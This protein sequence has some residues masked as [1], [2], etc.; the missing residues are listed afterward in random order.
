MFSAFFVQTQRT[1]F[2]LAPLTLLTSSGSLQELFSEPLKIFFE[3][4]VQKEKKNY[5]GDPMTQCL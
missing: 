2:L 1:N 3:H 5:K 4:K